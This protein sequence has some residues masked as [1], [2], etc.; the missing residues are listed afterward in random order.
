M[1]VDLEDITPPENEVF[2]SYYAYPPGP[3]VLLALTY[4][5]SGEYRYIYLRLLEA[6]ISS[7]GCLFIFL[8]G[9]TLFN[10]QIGLISAFIYAIYLPIAYGSTWALQDALMPFFTLLATYFFVIAV[11]KKS[12]LFY[13]LAGLVCGI[14]SYF[15]TTIMLLPF[16]LGSGLF[17]YRLKDMKFWKSLGHAAMMTAV[18]I[19]VVV[20]VISP[21]VVRNYNVTGHVMTTRGGL[22]QGIWEGFGEFSNPV[23]AVLN[24]EITYDQLIKE[25]YNVAYGTPEY[26]AVLRDKSIKAIKEHPLW[27][28][29]ILARRTPHTIIY[30]SEL[31]IT[32]YPRDSQGNILWNNPQEDAYSSFLVAVKSLDLKEAWGIAWKSPYAVFCSGL[33]LLFA[34]LPVLFGVIGIWLMRRKWKEIVL[35][36]MVPI[37]YAVVNIVFFVNW[38]TLVPGAMG[39]ILFSAIAIYFFALKLKLFHADNNT[40]NPVQGD[41]E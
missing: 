1:L 7:F 8:M 33:G 20:L 41:I 31:G 17:I 15:Q 27:W 39:W 6:V 14:G 28:L 4:K 36:A 23:G 30:W 9:R 26:D 10:R 2:V 37:Y 12:I 22:W 24:D 16:A 3:S 38:K 18:I 13:V 40:F 35:M 25:G 19:T 11:G 34:V 29:S 21:W 32:Q 5:I